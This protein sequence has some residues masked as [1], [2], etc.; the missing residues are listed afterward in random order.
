MLA[1]GISQ[2]EADDI[3]HQQFTGCDKPF[4]PCYVCN[5]S[6]RVPPPEGVT[7]RAKFWWIRSIPNRRRP[8]KRQHGLLSPELFQS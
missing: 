1:A 2:E 4:V 6:G 8:S 7:Y 5:R 3:Y